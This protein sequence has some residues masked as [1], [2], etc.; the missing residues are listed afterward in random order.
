[1]LSGK[2]ICPKCQNN[3][4]SNYLYYDSVKSNVENWF[5][6]NTQPEKKRWKCWA[7]LELCGKT[8]NHWYDP[9]GWCFNPCK[10]TPDVVT[11]V[12]GIEV[13][14]QKDAACGICCCII[15]SCVCY[16]IY[17]MYVTVFVWYD[18]YYYFC[19]KRKTE[20]VIF[21]GNGNMIRDSD[22]NY[23]INVNPNLYTENFWCYNYPNLFQCTR[24]NYFGKSFKEFLD[25]N[26][27]HNYNGDEPTIVN[28]NNN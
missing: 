15:F 7:L 13:N 5:F 2:L 28:I 20:K 4:M 22:S 11:T 21:N 16:L 25:I 17:A 19:K 8:P 3:G 23:W 27:S 9:C 26:Q 14:R 18:I 6:Y 12:N 24:C 10:Y 1:M